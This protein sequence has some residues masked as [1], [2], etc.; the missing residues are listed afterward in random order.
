MRSDLATTVEGLIG[1]ATGDRLAAAGIM[2]ALIAP[3]GRIR[4]ANRVLRARGD[5]A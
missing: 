2:A 3:D 5:G 4:A 1:G